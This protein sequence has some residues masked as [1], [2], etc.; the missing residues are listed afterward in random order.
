MAATCRFAD[1]VDAGRRLAAILPA[2]PPD[3]IVL[4]LARGGVPVAAEVAHALGVVLDVLVV[5]KVGHPQQPEYALG[6][7]SE[8]GIVLPAG[9]PAALAEPEL[10]RARSQAVALRGGRERVSLGGREAI[11][12]DDGLATG[13]SMRVALETV[14]GLGAARVA[15]AVPVASAPGLR[16]LDA[17]WE[18]YA[19]ESVESPEFVAVG[20][21]YDDFEP[22]DDVA[23]ARLLSAAGPPRSS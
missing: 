15:M 21:F 9:L 19:L 20:Q 2:A 6:A 14:A 18:V 3:T 11:V 8:D 13:R 22:V 5:R 23:V 7:V 1:R 12:V 17:D 4:G 16:E 10:R